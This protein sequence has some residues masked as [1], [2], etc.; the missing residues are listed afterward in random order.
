[1]NLEAAKELIRNNFYASSVHC[2]Y[3]AC[4]QLMMFK[5]VQNLSITYDDLK[6]RSKGESSHEYVSNEIMEILTKKSG[7]TIMQDFKRQY[8][9]LKRF[10]LDSDYH[11]ILIDSAG[12]SHAL[13]CS[14]E[15]LRMIKKH[16]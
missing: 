16:L 2:S 1:M 7:L 4:F 8:K 5:L 15:L 10:R 12:S 9:Q 6:N 3:Y 14:E 11:D 13:R